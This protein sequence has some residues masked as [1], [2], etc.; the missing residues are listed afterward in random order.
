MLGLNQRAHADKQFQ[1]FGW[2]L[3]QIPYLHKQQPLCLLEDF[4]HILASAE[5]RAVVVLIQKS[6]IHVR[7]RDIVGEFC[8]PRFNL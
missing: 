8:L 1:Q 6:Y 2:L 3:K 5:F 4:R 7:R